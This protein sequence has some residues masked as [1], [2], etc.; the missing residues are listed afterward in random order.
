VNAPVT[1]ILAMMAAQTPAAPQTA[2]ER[3]KSVLVLRDIP[4]DL[5]IPQ[6]PAAS[7]RLPDDVAPSPWPRRLAP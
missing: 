1:L 2:G 6:S 7:C 4:S 5:V 3:Y